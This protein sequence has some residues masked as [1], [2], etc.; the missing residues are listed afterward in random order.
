[1][2]LNRK[3][4]REFIIL[5][6]YNLEITNQDPHD[7]LT[8]IAEEKGV[9]VI[10]DYITEH[11]MGIREKREELDEIISRNLVNYTIERLS[12]IDLQILR[13]ATYEMVY[14]HEEVA[15][16]VS[17]NEAV[18]LAKMYSDLDDQKASSFVNSVLDKVRKNLEL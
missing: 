14:K 4:E 3:K 7:A 18:E 17:I 1:M 9:E 2:K 8:Y 6:L 15:P 11:V 10:S 5:A 16:T 13:Y 12:Y